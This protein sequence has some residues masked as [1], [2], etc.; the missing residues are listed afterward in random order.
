MIDEE[1]ADKLIDELNTLD[2]E[3]LTYIFNNLNIKFT[4][5]EIEAVE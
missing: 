1:K 5:K 3:T 4:L 2:S